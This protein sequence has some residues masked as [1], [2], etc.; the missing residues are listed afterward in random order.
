MRISVRFSHRSSAVNL[1]SELAP[2]GLYPP[3]IGGTSPLREDLGFEND[4]GNEATGQKSGP[5]IGPPPSQPIP[6]SP[7]IVTSTIISRSSSSNA[8]IHA[9]STP[10]LNSLTNVMLSP[11]P[12][13]P[14]SQSL[15]KSSRIPLTFQPIF[16]STFQSGSQVKIKQE[17]GLVQPT[18]RCYKRLIVY[19]SI[20]HRHLPPF[21]LP[22][23]Q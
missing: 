23:D 10:L 14:L 3:P 6:S 1:I 12:S 8:T 15:T 7:T 5:T 11:S 9:V 2:S 22:P 18:F 19:T 17:P 4:K 20:V 21:P 13:T 16:L